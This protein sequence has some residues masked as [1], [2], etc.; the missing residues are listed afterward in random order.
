MQMKHLRTLECID[1][2]ARTGSIRKAADRLALTASALNRRIQEFEAELGAPVFE[3]LPRGV[4]L[5]AAGELLI[6][7]ARAQFA[8]VERLRSQIAD[9]SGL[10]RGHVAVACSHA[11]AHSFLPAQVLAYR[12]EFPAVTF[13]LLVRDHLSAQR[14]L[15]DFSADLALVFEPAVQPE[16]ATLM[17]VDQPVH[18]VMA[19]GHPLAARPVVRLRDCLRHPLALP[20]RSFG[21]RQILEEALG[22][23]SLR[24]EPAIESNSFRAL[25]EIVRGSDAITF[26]IAVGAGDEGGGAGTVARPVDARDLRVGRL[27]LGQLRGRSLPVAAAKFADR[28]AAALDAMRAAEGDAP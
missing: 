4:R 6:R 15:I 22:F 23:R 21:G 19:V 16:M 27:V 9:L 20:D 28:L 25:R 12:A 24:V 5:N 2:V 7:H 8:D 1:A 13:E 17:A 3:R 18:A 11:A 10:R 26:Q 14:A